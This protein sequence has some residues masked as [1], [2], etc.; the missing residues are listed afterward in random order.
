MKDEKKYKYKFSIVSAVYNVEPY[1]DEMINSIIKQD[2]GFKENVQLILVDDG[3]TDNS[4]KIC[5]KWTQKYPNNIITIH[6]QN[7]GVSSARNEGLKYVEGK[8]YNFCDPDD[9]FSKNALSSVWKFFE[10]HEDEIDI[11]CI[12]MVFFGAQTGNHYLN[13]KF[14][15]GSRVIDLKKEYN[16]VLLSSASAFFNSINKNVLIF[17]ESLRISEDFKLI[18]YL[19]LQKQ[20]LGVVSDCKYLY[21]KRN[22]QSSATQIAEQ[23]EN[24]YFGVLE[25][26]ILPLLKETKQKYD[27]VPFFIQYA[28]FSDLRWKLNQPLQNNLLKDNPEKL[29]RYK[30]LLFECFNYASVS[31]INSIK[32]YN[33]FDRYFILKNIMHKKITSIA[34]KT[35]DDMRYDCENNKIFYLSK[36]AISLHFFEYKN[37]QVTITFA[38]SNLPCMKDIDVY[39]KVN[40][41]MIKARPIGREIQTFKLD[42]PFSRQTFYSITFELSLCPIYFSFYFVDKSKNKTIINLNHTYGKFFPLNNI[43]H[44]YF[45]FGNYIFK[46]INS[47]T[48]LIKRT[49]FFYNLCNELK[50]DKNILK[51]KI[52]K[53]HK[54]I[55]M[56]WYYKLF[57]MLHKKPRCII[58]DRINKAGDNGEAFFRYLKTNKKNIIYNFAISKCQDYYKLKKEFKNIVIFNSKKYY[59]K[60]LT[61]NYMI[62]SHADDFV[63][64]P[65][66]IKHNYLKDLLYNE[67]FIFLQHGVISNDL[68]GWLNK[69]KKNISGFITS[70]KPETKSIFTY[71]Y[72]YPKNNIWETGLPRFDRLYHNEQR[73]ITIMPTWRKYLTTKCDSTTGIL[74]LKPDF[75]ESAFFVFYNN[76]INNKKLLK[77]CKRYNYTLCFMPHPNIIPH[78]KLFDKNKSVVFMDINKPYREIYAESNLVLTDYSSAIYDFVYLNKPIIYSQF[79]KDEFFAGSHVYTQGYFDYE[80]DGFGEVCYD[81]KSTVNTII[82][83]MKNDC[84]LKPIYEERINN[85]F[86]FRDSNNCERVYNE[87]LKL[88]QRNKPAPKKNLKYY[89]KQFFTIKKQYGLKVAI[90]WT[91]DHFKRVKESKKNK[92]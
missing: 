39:L 25:N 27:E 73:F 49:N 11:V 89:I 30:E 41:K 42:E 71:D 51:A 34:C 38:F 92:K 7:G 72:C 59:L 17:D 80:K 40:G 77:A 74:Q 91:K 6:K 45:V 20:K 90:T 16:Y 12:P 37:N 46:A 84:K 4:G 65:L 52:K 14:S 60:C 10:K 13:N 47:G 29:N 75:K 48:F 26:F 88:E 8:Y 56:R 87:I 24:W 57:K 23:N 61:A 15:Q 70:A 68:S 32:Y 64:N 3:S 81:L 28:I 50:Y 43:P 44:S 76:L 21:R 85:F 1:L 22:D 54:I 79:D 78:I 62:S 36:A 33:G 18:I 66:G 58:T 5:D 53:G 19:L 83:Y 35:A 82:D 9:K 63:T 69:Y 86:A 55:L 67:H 2:I 31:L